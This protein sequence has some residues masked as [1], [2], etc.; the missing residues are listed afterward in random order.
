VLNAGEMAMLRHS[1]MMAATDATRARS[2]V[3]ELATRVEALEAEN[4]DLRRMVTAL[5][6]R[7]GVSPLELDAAAAAAAPTA[8]SAGASAA[9][10]AGSAATPA[11]E[12]AGAADSPNPDSDAEP[13][14]DAGGAPR[15]QSA[16]AAEDG[17]GP[18]PPLPPS[19][20]ILDAR[21][22]LG[23]P[24]NALAARATSDGYLDPAA[25]EELERQAADTTLPTAG[26]TLLRRRSNRGTGRGSRDYGSTPASGTVPSAYGYVPPVSHH[27]AYT[28]ADPSELPQPAATPSDSYGVVMATAGARAGSVYGACPVNPILPLG[29][30]PPAVDATL[31]APPPAAGAANTAPAPSSPGGQRD[32][33]GEWQTACN[34]PGASLEDLALRAGAMHS[35]SQAFA[36]AAQECV[37]ALVDDLLRQPSERTLAAVDVGGIAGASRAG[38]EGRPHA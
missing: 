12:P 22:V 13:S 33:F 4:R 28:S 20:H 18:V 31:H 32:W 37:R 2:A 1:L 14:G 5:A 11:N 34:A 19:L 25:L 7:V 23:L 3:N 26:P 9:V 6:A 16:D 38:R 36:T 15:K 17:G 35:V 8:E 30:T 10:A 27:H 29:A 21:Y 24:M